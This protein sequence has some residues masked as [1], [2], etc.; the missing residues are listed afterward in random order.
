MADEKCEVIAIA[1][2]RVPVMLLSTDLPEYAVI[3]QALFPERPAIQPK[4]PKLHYIPS[5]RKNFCY[6]FYH[7]LDWLGWRHCIS[8]GYWKSSYKNVWES[9]DLEEI[10]VCLG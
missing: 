4:H 3:M 1:E 9:M 10:E 6:K 5:D 2:G 7:H 8:E